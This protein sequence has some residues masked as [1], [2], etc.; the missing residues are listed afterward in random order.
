MCLLS[1]PKSPASQ[2]L[3]ASQMKPLKPKNPKKL[4]TF[5]FFPKKDKCY[6][7][8][9]PFSIPSSSYSHP[10]I[11]NISSLKA[12]LITCILKKISPKSELLIKSYCILSE[13][14][15]FPTVWCSTTDSR[16]KPQKSQKLAAK[17]YVAWIGL[18]SRIL[19]FLIDEVPWGSS[20]KNMFL[21]NYKAKGSLWAWISGQPLDHFQNYF[22]IRWLI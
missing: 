15:K 18:Q 4:V 17:P 2:L 19:S 5:G 16:R 3:R 12:T 7:I 10:H 22:G 14:S 20:E 21:R 6:L 13:N 11:P 1:H 9:A 8:T